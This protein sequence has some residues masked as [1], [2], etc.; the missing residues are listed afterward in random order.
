MNNTNMRESESKERQY[1][2]FEVEK[3][4]A[5]HM[6]NLICK[7]LRF[8]QGHYEAPTTIELKVLRKELGLRKVDLCR[9]IDISLRTMTER[10][11]GNGLSSLSR[12]EFA[13]IF[14]FVIRATKQWQ[15]HECSNVICEPGVIERTPNDETH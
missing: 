11:S 6:Q 15:N 5:L 13:M 10:E 3:N 14:L 4:R 7:S 12:H 9:K 2:R 8:L 1:R